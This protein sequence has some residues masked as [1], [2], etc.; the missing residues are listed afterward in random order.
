M[1]TM[2]EMYFWAGYDDAYYLQDPPRK[3]DD[4]YKEEYVIEYMRGYKAGKNHYS[5][6]RPS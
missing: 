1:L 4:A 5:N 3:F 6:G 2:L